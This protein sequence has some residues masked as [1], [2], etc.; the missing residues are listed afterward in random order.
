VEK[1]REATAVKTGKSA[2][3]GL[4]IPN[5]SGYTKNEGWS[6]V[7]EG[8]GLLF[9]GGNPVKLPSVSKLCPVLK[10][11]GDLNVIGGDEGKVEVILPHNCCHMAR[12]NAELQRCLE[13]GSG[14]SRGGG[15][16]RGGRENF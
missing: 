11:R 7:S 10:G 14:Q 3:N 15:T 13:S 12:N 4:V 1:V 9:G 5:E 16:K 8:G 6:G 2:Y